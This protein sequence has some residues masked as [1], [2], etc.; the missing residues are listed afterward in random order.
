[1]EMKYFFIMFVLYS[2]FCLLMFVS[3]ENFSFWAATFFICAN[4]W[5]A[6]GS[7]TIK[8]T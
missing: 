3:K 2:F 8:K 7:T 6:V 4:V 5:L 1:M